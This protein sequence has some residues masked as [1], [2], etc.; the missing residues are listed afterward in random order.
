MDRFR[1][2]FKLS[3]HGV[4]FSGS[5]KQRKEQTV[6]GVLEG[7]LSRLFHNDVTCV[8]C[9]RTDVG[10]HAD[11]SYC[12]C[13]FLFEFEPKN[14]MSSLNKASLKY[15]LV[16][17]SIQMVPQSFHALSSVK[18]R[19]YKYYFTFDSL[20]P[21]YLLHSITLVSK[22]AL[23]LPTSSELSRLLKGNRNFFSLCNYS[24]STKTYI[25]FIYDV[26][27]TSF[28]YQP[29]DGECVQMHCI[30]VCANGFLYKMMRHIMGILLHSMVN[31][32]NMSRLND[33]VLINRPFV[34]ALAPVQGLRLVE[35][36]Y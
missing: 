31:F 6:Y 15:G 23:F 2:L 16:I 13:D 28:S 3:Y 34:Y 30:S 8:P 29:I 24:A 14:I 36:N 12:H 35:V 25:R 19:R 32:T 5:Q 10:V 26:E 18:S 20:V 9:G 33:Y 27:F 17:H 11:Q 4:L 1:Y 21:T 22:P 7:L